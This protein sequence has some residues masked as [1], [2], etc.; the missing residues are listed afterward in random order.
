MLLQK[1]SVRQ[2]SSK[3]LNGSIAGH[4]IGNYGT[5]IFLLMSYFNLADFHCNRRE[6][7]DSFKC[8]LNVCVCVCACECVFV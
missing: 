7:R 8:F 1:E 2:T 3:P 6:S 4:S 5:S